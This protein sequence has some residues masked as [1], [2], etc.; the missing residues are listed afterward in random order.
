MFEN[1]YYEVRAGILRR[2]S[3]SPTTQIS[4]VTHIIAHERYEKATM[5]HDIALLRIKPKLNFN[6]WVRPICM[7][8]KDRVGTTD[9]VFGPRAGTM[10]ATLGFGAIK[11]RGPDSDDLQVV[12]IPILHKCKY[13][14]DIEGGAVCAGERDGRKDAC[15]GW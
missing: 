12:E 7:P 11:E 2:S 6:K 14:N 9:W 5:K 10:C 8:S 3:H 1:H 15:Q 13:R 4:V